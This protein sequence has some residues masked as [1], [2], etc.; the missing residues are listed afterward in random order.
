MPPEIPYEQFRTVLTMNL[1]NVL[2]LDEISA[3]LFG[4]PL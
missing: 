2:P 3:E 4:T 1:C